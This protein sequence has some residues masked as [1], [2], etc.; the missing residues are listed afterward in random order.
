M[1]QSP[2]ILQGLVAAAA[3]GMF[4]Q[5]HADPSGVKAGML[6]CNVNSGWGLVFGSSRRLDCTFSPDST[7]T[8]RY[9]GKINKYGVD[10]GYTSG[11]VMIWAVFAPTNSVSPGSLSG[12]YAG[13]TGGASV[14][15]GAN[16]NVLVGGSG[17]HISLQPVSIEGATGLN[18][19][20]GVAS[21]QL[22]HAP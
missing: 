5:A 21:I 12:G 7:H 11:G 16:A 2:R 17:N 13:V 14:G 1:K 19:A 18:V 4:A 6:T 9:L 22:S 10:I 3:L 20:A 8:D 15:V